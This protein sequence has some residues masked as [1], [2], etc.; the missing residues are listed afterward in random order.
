MSSVGTEKLRVYWA[1]AST[2]L[3]W[4]STSIWNEFDCIVGG[5]VDP[6]PLPVIGA[7]QDYVVELPWVPPNPANY[8]G[9]IHFC[10][11]A[12]IET[13]PSSPFGMTYDESLNQWLWQNVAGNNNIV[14]KNVT[15][16]T[17]GGGKGKLIVRNPLRQK[18]VMALRFAVPREEV[19][20]NF[21]LH[22]EIFV[23]L[24]QALMN[25][26]RQSGQPPRGFVLHDNTTIK[27]TDAADAVLDGLLFNPGEERTIEVRMQLKRGNK[28]KPGMSFNWD[29][30]QQLWPLAAKSS[31][32]GGERYTLIV[33][34]AE[35][36]GAVRDR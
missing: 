12:R 16:F 14:W 23:K 3:P 19:K 18:A 33:P 22:G 36:Q 1:N 8:G 9:S 32:I 29:V 5:G 35:Q 7:G 31:A 6:C 34:K 28:A 25:K 27:I 26:W 20:N 24:D 30:T 15:V 10:L 11:V 21:L 17:S 13:A 2:A 4:P